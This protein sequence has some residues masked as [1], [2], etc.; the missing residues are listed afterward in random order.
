MLIKQETLRGVAAGSITL[1][2]RRW[3][4]PT[5]KAG[6]TLL[7]T[8]GL[9][10]IDSV[11]QVDLGDVTEGEAVKAGFSDLAEL[12][13]VLRRHTEGSI[14]R[15][16]L[17]PAGPDPRIALRDKVPEDPEELAALRARMARW[18]EGSKA[19]P[20]TRAVLS[21]LQ[22]K[23]AIRAADLSTDIGMDKDR[24]KANVRKLKGL[25]LTES[26]E[27]GYRLSARGEAVLAFIQEDE[28]Q[29]GG[30]G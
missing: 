11:E 7:T 16:S 19:G 17:R 8:A 10:A 3:R 20:W 24:F 1:A 27:V 29:R 26:L 28:R 14:Y 5:V 22:R 30:H 4:R 6:G 15:I 25:G 21:L 18:D 23:P 13:S 2:F 12:H 9:L